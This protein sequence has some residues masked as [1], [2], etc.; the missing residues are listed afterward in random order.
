MGLAHLLFWLE[1][2]IAG[3]YVGVFLA[4]FSFGAVSFT[5]VSCL[6]H[7]AASVLHNQSISQ[8]HAP[9]GISRTVGTVSADLATN[10]G[11]DF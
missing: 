10:G 7:P 3:L 4:A 11:G 2:G 8:L 1:L 9:R 5:S 6:H